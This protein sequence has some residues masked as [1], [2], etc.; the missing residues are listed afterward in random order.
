MRKIGMG[1]WSWL[2]PTVTSAMQREHRVLAFLTPSRRRIGL[3]AIQEARRRPLTSPLTVRGHPE[4]IGF[5]WNARVASDGTNEVVTYLQGTLYLKNI[6]GSA[7]VDRLATRQLIAFTQG[8]S[9][10]SAPGSGIADGSTV[11][12]FSPADIAAMQRMSGCRF[13]PAR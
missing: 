12:T 5:E 6:A 13:Q 1:T 8:V 9:A 11:D 4:H 7:A 2:L 10:S 3:R